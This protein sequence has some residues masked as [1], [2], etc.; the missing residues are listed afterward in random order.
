MKP[1]CDYEFFQGACC[2]LPLSASRDATDVFHTQG[3]P[4]HN[5][6]DKINL[7]LVD[8]TESTYLT[9]PD[10]SRWCVSVHFDS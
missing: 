2:R 4:F 10:P 7:T 8:I 1:E 9:F 6:W 5:S 3:R